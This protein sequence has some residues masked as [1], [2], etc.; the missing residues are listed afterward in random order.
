MLYFD[1]NA[2]TPV[3]SEVAEAMTAAVRDVFGN[4]SSTHQHG[5]CARQHLENARR[6][7]AGALEIAPAEFVFTSGGTESN[8]LA[9]LGLMRNLPE[10]RKHAITTTIEHPS[11]LETFRQL[12]REG[13]DVA[14]VGVD[15]DGR[16]D[17]RE[18]AHHLR[19]ETALVSVMH[20][21][22]ETGV[23][24]PIEEI[25]AIVRSR[26][27]AGQR[28]WFHSDGVQA[29][30]KIPVNLRTLDIDLYAV[31][32]HKIYAPKGIGGLF[33]RKGVPLGSTH[34]GGRHERE[35]RPGTENVPAAVAFAVAME[36]CA[37]P[38]AR[39]TAELRDSFEAK[40][41]SALPD[42]EV[43]GGAASRLPNTSNLL[44]RGVSGE[45]LL[46]ALDIQGMAVSTGSACSSGSIEPSQVLLSMGRS[47]EEA[48]SSVR[49]SLGRYNTN[50]EVDR[51]AEAVI[52]C[53]GQLRKSHK[54]EAQLV[55]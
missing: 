37:A 49:F 17:T 25:A 18:I 44:F 31:S 45:G 53:T 34:H 42:V 38:D 55:L 47:R 9:I 35:R 50:E 11:V 27:E 26:R 13:V 12:E 8:N 2:T 54:S 39:S 28:I 43:N 22:N 16:V 46:I 4:P 5:Q 41:L 48:K 21:N 7:I 10:A 14:Y 1:H 51:L 19:P 20:A 33:V 15:R 52:A 30:G 40:V 36:F 24:Q 32:A 29:M 3:A 23:I 6:R